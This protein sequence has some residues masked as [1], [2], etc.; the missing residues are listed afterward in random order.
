MRAER[1]LVLPAAGA[2]RRFGGDTPKP[3]APCEGVPM[4][5][6]VIRAVQNHSACA[7]VIVVIRSE[8]HDR[9]ETVFGALSMDVRLVIDDS[10]GGSAGAVQTALALVDTSE[11]I[12]AWPD[13]LGAEFLPE[14]VFTRQIPPDR[15]GFM[16]VVQRE[17]PY[18]MVEVSPS[19]DIRRFI[20]PEEVKAGQFTAGFSDCGVFVVRAE[21]CRRFINDDAACGA[22]DRNL[23]SILGDQ[24]EEDA[25]HAVRVTDWRASLGV[26]SEADLVFFNSLRTT[27]SQG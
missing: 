10:Y 15:S 14:D 21:A 8:H 22:R 27:G 17:D 1:T 16:P 13:H 12:V 24:Q 4:V 6:R 7:E 26:N 9:F 18:A 25:L 20:S 5:V 11:I 23:V 2:G 3:L 19:G